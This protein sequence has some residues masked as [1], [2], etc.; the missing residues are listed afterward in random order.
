MSL[1]QLDTTNFYGFNLIANDEREDFL[2]QP[3]SRIASVPYPDAGI[4]VNAW[5][6]P[7]DKLV[8]KGGVTE[9]DN[10]QLFWA[11]E[12]VFRPKIQ[13]LGRG[14][15]RLLVYSMRTQGQARNGFALSF[16]QQIG[17]H[18][19]PFMTYGQSDPGISEIERSFSAGLGIFGDSEFYGFFSNKD[20]IGIGYAW[21]DPSNKQLRKEQ[22]IEVYY[23]HQ[24]GRFV[25]V[26]PDIQFVIDPTYN[27]VDG[28]VVVLGLRVQATFLGSRYAGGE[29]GKY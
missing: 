2:S 19:V 29:R 9:A 23:R 18:L 24:L 3:L 22:V 20:V 11:A 14:H 8:F 15:Y 12:G 28:L 16:D 6:I 5:W 17:K 26:T 1:G 27:P 10:D 7:D 21:N 13:N 4:G 25:R